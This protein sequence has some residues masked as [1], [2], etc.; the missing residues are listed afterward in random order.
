MKNIL[1]LKPSNTSSDIPGSG[2]MKN[3][4]QTKILHLIKTRG[5]LGANEVASL[6]NMTSMGARQHMEL[7]EKN[8][9]L[10]HYFVS[11]GRGRPK[12]KWLLTQRG[13]SQ[14]P[15]SHSALI[16]NLLDHMQQQFGS[17][18]LEQLIIAREKEIL[19]N[20]EQ[21]LA[22]LP[23]FRQKLHRLAELRTEEGYMADVTEEQGELLLVENNCP[24]CSAATKCQQFCRSE[25]SIFQQLLDCKLER[26]NYILKGGR[27]C[28]Y[29]IS[30]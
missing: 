27:R 12:K 23:S 3:A 24:I 8:G 14:F 5:Q 29:K 21:Q 19:K 2:E 6:L 28:A 4:N 18:A 1:D 17:D 9:L 22:P 15:D 20:Y 10:E 30:R 16:V 7:L 25:L 26:I 13:Q 11:S